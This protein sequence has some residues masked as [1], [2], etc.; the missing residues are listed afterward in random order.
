MTNKTSGTT[1]QKPN[2]IIR[3]TIPV[4]WSVALDHLA[5]DL[6]LSKGALLADGALMLLRH[7]GRGEGLGDLVSPMF[8]RGGER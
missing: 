1:P 6:G 5:L 2:V 4:A 3:T 7:H 8:V